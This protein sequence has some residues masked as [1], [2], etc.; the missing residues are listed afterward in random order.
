MTTKLITLAE[1]AKRLGVQPARVRDLVN[2]GV[3]EVY[4]A[5]PWAKRF[6]SETEVDAYRM[7]RDEKKSRA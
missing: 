4:V 5:H 1:A 7:L 2:K 6:V 3:L